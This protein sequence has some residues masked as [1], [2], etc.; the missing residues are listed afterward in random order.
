MQT[1]TYR[2]IEE[3]PS[4]K[5]ALT[6]FQITYADVPYLQYQITGWG[7]SAV[8]IEKGERFSES[9]GSSIKY[10]KENCE[11]GGNLG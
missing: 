11:G 5:P 1:N 4:S 3:N 6:I 2:I 10:V 8:P 7:G 9:L